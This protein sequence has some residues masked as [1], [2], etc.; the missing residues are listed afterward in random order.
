MPDPAPVTNHGT[1]AG[2][3]GDALTRAALGLAEVLQAENTALKA[4]DFAAAGRLLT[5]KEAATAALT[6]AQAATLFAPPGLR[7]IALQLNVL[8]DENRLL[9][10]RAIAVQ[11]RVLGAVARAAQTASPE[12]YYGPGGARAVRPMAAVALRADA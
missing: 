12:P 10:E 11:R 8:A 1:G 3:G 2:A 5:A 6:A 9:L 7:A 4:L